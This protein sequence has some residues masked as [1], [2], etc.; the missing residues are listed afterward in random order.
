[1]NDKQIIKQARDN[2]Q[3]EAC[4]H[5]WEIRSSELA[6]AK[7]MIGPGFLPGFAFAFA[8]VPPG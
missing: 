1:M 7:L 2:S 3:G 4:E 6:A 8:S 5:K